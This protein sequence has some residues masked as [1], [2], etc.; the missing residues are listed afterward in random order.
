MGARTR[1]FGGLLLVHT[2][3]LAADTPLEL[4]RAGLEKCRDA[5][6]RSSPQEA[7]AAAETAESQFERALELSP[8][9]VDARVGRARVLLECRM[10]PADMMERMAL[11]QAIEGDL[12]AALALDPRHWEARFLLAT[13]LYNVP[14]FL[15]RGGDAIEHLELLV[16]QQESSGAPQSAEPY[17]MLGDLLE[18]AGEDDRAREVWRRGARLHPASDV[19]RERAAGSGTPTAPPD[20]D[21]VPGPA[22]AGDT[23]GPVSGR[24]VAHLERAAS[25]RQIAG[26]SVGIERKG[27]PILVRGFGWADLE[28]EVSATS[29]TVYAI[30]SITK[31]FMAAT[32]LLLVDRGVLILDGEVAEWLPEPVRPLVAG[33][34]IRHLLS[35]TSGLPQDAVA[36]GDWLRDSLGEPRSGAPGERYFYSN[37]GYG[38]LGLVV[39][40]ATERP[41]E[42]TLEDHLLSPLAMTAT[43]PCSEVEI[44]PHRGRGY[45]WQG[46]RM[47][48][49]APVEGS[50][51]LHFAGGLC[52]TVDDL[53]RW[54]RGLHGGELLAPS[55]YHAMITPPPLPHGE[56]TTYAFGL[57]A[58]EV[59]GRRVLQ[60]SGATGGFLSE[61]AY[62]PDDDLAVVVL[63]NSDGGDP[64]ALGYDLARIVLDAARA[65]S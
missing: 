17:V 58:Q 43:H 45:S 50:P 21:L 44:V 10:G 9:S 62:Y 7:A 1:V 6:R 49:A 31:Q 11:M 29:S 4:G 39:E 38:L 60:H 46:D 20:P 65:A 63:M 59:G 47:V 53:L 8:A 56:L 13:L 16:E 35:H 41:W 36:S 61:L 30:G 33:I 18:R 22:P 19:L 64:R 52:S 27:E 2:L 5:T 25:R 26:L 51:A 57:R 15:G 40:G 34:R 28:H 55:S 32:I 42:E 23:L 12:G 37:L 54:L 24:L 14:P 3:A 48:N